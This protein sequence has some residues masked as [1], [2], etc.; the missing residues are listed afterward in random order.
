MRRLV[1]SLLMIALLG[2]MGPPAAAQA[3]TTSEELLSDMVTEGI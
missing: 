2:A 1:T 3:P